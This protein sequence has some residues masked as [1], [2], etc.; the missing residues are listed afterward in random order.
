LPKAGH[1]SEQRRQHE[2]QS[3]FRRGRRY[4]AG[5]EGRISVLKR[6]H[7]LGRCLN[8]G[9]DGFER[10]VGWGVIANNLTIIGRTRAIHA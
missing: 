10:W 4:H 6:K 2:R 1:K 7:G 9:R 8:H 3:W 5:I